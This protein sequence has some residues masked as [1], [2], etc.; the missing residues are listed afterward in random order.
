MPNAYSILSR[1]P[2]KWADIGRRVLERDAKKKAAA[3]KRQK[4]YPKYVYPLL[5]SYKEMSNSG[6][7]RLDSLEGAFRFFFE[8]S[9]TKLGYMQAKLKEVVI[10]AFL[11][12]MFGDDLVANLKYLS[13]K[14]DITRFIDTVAIL[15]ARR[16]GKTMGCAV[17]IAALVVSQPN[18]HLVM[19]NLTA[20]QAEEFIAEVMRHMEVYRE[21]AEYGWQV[22][23]IDVRRK[24]CI[25]TNKYGT[26][27]SVKSYACAL[28]GDG[29]IDNSFLNWVCLFLFFP[30]SL[31]P[32][33]YLLSTAFAVLTERTNSRYSLAFH[34]NRSSASC[35]DIL[36]V[37]KWCGCRPSV[38]RSASESFR[39]CS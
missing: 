9:E 4:V 25:K 33:S 24:I 6:R 12:N 10:A 22:D 35:L 27:N 18:C 7:K 26:I 14:F 2:I 21:S 31:P 5:D 34:A 13:K 39:H 29:K 1:P 36:S 15:F 32:L 20:Q 37:C 28:R 16:S 11:K 19:Y 23:R 30:P 17:I 3:F 8:N 38:I